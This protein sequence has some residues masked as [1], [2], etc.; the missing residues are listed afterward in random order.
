MKLIKG[1]LVVIMVVALFGMPHPA[2]AQIYTY[3]SGYQVQNLST[4]MATITITYYNQQTD[5]T[6]TGTTG[7]QVF[8]ATDSIDG[9][10]SKTYFPVHAPAGFKGSVVISSSAPLASIANIVATGVGNASYVGSTGGSTTAYLPL[11]MK[12][13]AG[14][15][16]WYSVQ[17]TSASNATVNVAYSD[18]T[19]VG[20]VVIKPSASYVFK[21]QSETHSLKV[22]SATLTSTQ[23][24]AVVVVQE[25]T[26]VKTIL[27]QTGF[28]AGETNALMPLINANNSGYNTG[29][30]IQN[31]GT[32]DT[33]ITVSYTPVPG[34]GTACTETRTITKG[35]SVT[36]AL[37][38]FAQ[39]APTTASDCVKARFVGGA[40]IT[41]NTTSQPV[42]AVVNQTTSK[43]AG[44]YDSFAPTKATGKIVLPLIMDRNSGWY[45]GFTL[46]NVGN[47][48]VHVVCTFTNTSYQVVGDLDPS[49]VLLDIQ[50]NKIADRYV[51]SGS[52]TATGTGETKIVAVVNEI[53]P[54]TG[55]TLLV[56][57]GINVTP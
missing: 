8:S 18:G 19:S 11:L 57:E 22:F 44:A 26:V 17:N 5:T 34:L 51:G 2:S 39:A 42:V 27:A 10:K 15:Y 14:I 33:D 20:P 3:T 50:L 43:I 54:G 36:F 16:T 55:D 48:A 4:S 46:A 38:A 31:I 37:F 41:G 25:G 45:T 13:N 32:A 53:A 1:L 7:V 12:A 40:Q 56:Y 6:G 35:A 29:V 28:D 9:L 49:G 47:A 23:P 21:Q 30:Q 24:V 52:C